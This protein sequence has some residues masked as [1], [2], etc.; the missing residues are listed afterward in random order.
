MSADK[1]WTHGTCS[2]CGEPLEMDLGTGD[3]RRSHFT[4]VYGKDSGVYD[5]EYGKRA[6]WDCTA[7][8][9]IERLKK[10]GRWKDPFE[11]SPVRPV[12]DWA[13]DPRNHEQRA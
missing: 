7:P 4:L 11:N 1:D 2:I 9:K 5:Y 10:D 12:E 3:L 6:T 13:T 8:G